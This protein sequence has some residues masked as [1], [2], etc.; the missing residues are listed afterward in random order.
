MTA[1]MVEPTENG[2]WLFSKTDDGAWWHVYHSNW[3]AVY[4]TLDAVFAKIK[5]RV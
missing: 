5:E 4:P 1:W 2:W 3:F